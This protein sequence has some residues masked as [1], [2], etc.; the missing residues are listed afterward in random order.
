M[1]IITISDFTE[2][3]IQLAYDNCGGCH[4]CGWKSPLS[5]IDY[6]ENTNRKGF[7]NEFNAP[8]TNDEIK[9]SEFHRGYYIYPEHTI[10]EINK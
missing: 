4:S 2:E 9:D 3:E 7:P 5:I 6:W 8:C 10:K 1:N